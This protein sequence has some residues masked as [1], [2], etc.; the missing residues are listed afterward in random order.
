MELDRRYEAIRRRAPKSLDFAALVNR[1]RTRNAAMTADWRARFPGSDAAVL[2]I[3]VTVSGQQRRRLRRYREFAEAS[4]GQPGVLILR[5]LTGFNE[6]LDLC[7][8]EVAA[9][10]ARA[11][12]SDLDWRLLSA[13]EALRG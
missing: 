9:S 6:F 5:Q 10:A 1:V 3:T 8:V 7:L 2:E 12:V 4:R 11:N 13:S